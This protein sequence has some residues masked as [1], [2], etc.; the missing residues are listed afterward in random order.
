[1]DVVMHEIPKVRKEMGYIPLVTPTS[2]IVGVQAVM[3]VLMGGRYKSVPQESKDIFAGKYGKTPVPV[4]PEIQKQV[5]GDEKPITCR[6]A[7]LIPDEFDKLKAEI[8]DKS[9]RDEDV[10]SY[11]LFPKVWLDFWAKKH[12]P[13]EEA[14]PAAPTSAQAS[15]ATAPSH[16][17]GKDG[18]TMKL[19]V[20]IAGG[21][22]KAV[23]VTFL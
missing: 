23:E 10:L 12:A 1:M 3:N 8:A 14:K 17:G 19:D 4:D 6:P 15:P 16:N 5:L 20:A 11:A 7:D 2:Q 9:D 21:A 13:K 22:R 18:K